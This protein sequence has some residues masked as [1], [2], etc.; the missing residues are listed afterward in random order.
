MSS[1]LYRALTEWRRDQCV[2][3]DLASDPDQYV[4]DQINGLSQHDFLRELGDAMDEILSEY[5]EKPIPNH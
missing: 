3:H 5:Q 4:E 1:Q 2:K